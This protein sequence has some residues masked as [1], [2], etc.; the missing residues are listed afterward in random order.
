VAAVPGVAKY[1]ASPLRMAK[2]NGNDL[3]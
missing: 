1:L 2:V 3:G